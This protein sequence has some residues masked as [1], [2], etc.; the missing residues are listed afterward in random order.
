MTREPSPPLFVA[1]GLACGRSGK[2]IVDEVDFALAAGEILFLLGPNGAGKTTL[3]Q[4]LLRRLKPLAGEMLLSGENVADWPAARFARAA[5]YVPQ[6]HKPPFPFSVFDVVLMGRSAHHGAFSAPSRADRECAE[7]ALESLGVGR[8]RDRLVTEISGGERQLVLFARAL[9]QRPKLLILD[10]PTASLDFG[11]Q[12]AVLG[13]ARALAKSKGLG[14]ILAAHD[15]NHALAYAD[16][17]ALIGRDGAFSIGAPETMITADWLEKT[18]AVKTRVAPPA[19]PGEP[20]FC[21]PVS[22]R[23]EE[24]EPCAL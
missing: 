19:R 13:H 4:T 11:N 21:L 20:A 15:P 6:S 14:I 18:Y 24:D 22:R 3:L 9:A 17:V 12:I 10:E 1:H 16:R 8:L 2:V 5:A 7:E 23:R